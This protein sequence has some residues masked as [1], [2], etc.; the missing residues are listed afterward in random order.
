M[1]EKKVDSRYFLYFFLA[2]GIFFFSGCPPDEV[3]AP[4]PQP[5]VTLR[6][7][8]CIPNQ[9]PQLIK[10]PYDYEWNEELL[11]TDQH[12]IIQALNGWSVSDRGS[13]RFSRWEVPGGNPNIIQIPDPYSSTID[14]TTYTCGS[15]AI[16][17][18]YSYR[19][20]GPAAT[21]ITCSSEVIWDE[22]MLDD[23]GIAIRRE[24]RF[25][26]INRRESKPISTLSFWK[27]CGSSPEDC[28]Y[29]EFVRWEIISG[30][31][32]VDISNP[33]ACYTSVTILNCDTTTTLSP[34]YTQVSH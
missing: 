24:Q 19:P 29:H 32:N 6:W 11:F 12:F 5:C 28:I 2:T 25:R 18:G 26:T 15:V 1:K 17:P 7:A 13:Y 14:I 16:Q 30:E 21:Q 22:W 10:L 34:V 23:E 8:A 9:E 4:E 20:D 33:E 31:N 27:E 3:P